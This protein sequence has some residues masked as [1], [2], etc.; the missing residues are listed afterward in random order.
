VLHRDIRF[1]N[2][3]LSRPS[4]FP[5]APAK[6]YRVPSRTLNCSPTWHVVVGTNF[7]SHVVHQTKNF[8]YFNIGAI[9]FLVY[10]SG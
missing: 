2:D 1:P 5:L 9:N 8:V 10:K 6:S 3:A 4:H 7:G